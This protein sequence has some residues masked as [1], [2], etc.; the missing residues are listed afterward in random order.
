MISSRIYTGMRLGDGSVWK[1]LFQNKKNLE[2]NLFKKIQ[3]ALISV[4]L[5]LWESKTRGSLNL[6]DTNLVAGSLKD[7][8]SWEY[9]KELDSK[10]F[11]IVF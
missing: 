7:P 3:P 2:S 10:K 8:I 11:R 5:G 6:L 9:N 1:C 4:T